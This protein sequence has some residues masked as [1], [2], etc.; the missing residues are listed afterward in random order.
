MKALPE[1]CDGHLDECGW[2]LARSGLDEK[3]LESLRSSAFEAGQA[4]KRCLLDIPTV[5]EAAIHLREVLVRLEIFQRAV[6]IQAIGFD[7]TEATNWKV[8]WHQDLMFPFAVPVTTSGFDLPVKK[9]GVDYARPPR[10]VLECLL[11]VRLH[12]DDCDEANG[13]L[14]ICPGSHR[15]GIIPGRAVPDYVAQRGEIMCPATSGDL[16][17]MRPL[18]LHASFQATKPR[19]RRV[20]HFVY[21]SGPQLLEKWYREVEELSCNS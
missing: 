17:L 21:Y 6:A 2:V 16:L 11:A 4:G 5:N 3:M 1:L 15:E 14:R 13:P 9:D 8:A 10:S 7:K 18:T 12:L 20:L 19:R